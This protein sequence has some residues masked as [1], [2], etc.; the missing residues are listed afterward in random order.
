MDIRKYCSRKRSASVAEQGETSSQPATKSQALHTSDSDRQATSTP[1]GKETTKAEKKK[2]Y[3]SRRGYKKEW[4]HNY[5]W[6]YCTDH[7][8][9]MF[10]RLCQEH[11]KLPLTAKGGWTSRGVLRNAEWR[12]F[13]TSMKGDQRK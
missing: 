7:A 8:K 9:G 4:E 13:L 1:K 5:P 10:C 2:L 12:C 11:G 3:K 6:V